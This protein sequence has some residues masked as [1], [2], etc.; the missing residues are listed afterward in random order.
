MPLKL[1]LNRAASRLKGSS[2]SLDPALPLSAMFGLAM[3]R[4][5]WLARGTLAFPLRG[6]KL[7]L[8][9]NVILRNRGHF[10]FGN[11][12]TLAHGC[13]IDGLSKNG[14]KLGRNV[15]VGPNTIIQA[16]GVLSNLGTG[17]SIG[18]NSGI[19]GFSF[20]GCGGGVTIG[21]NVIMGQ[22]VSFHSENH[23]I[24]RTDVPI[25]VQGVTRKGIVVE[26]DCWVGAKTTFLDG[27]HI[28]RGCVIA[29]GSVVRGDI[30][31]YS[32]AAGVPAKV[33]R[34]RLP[35]GQQP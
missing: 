9:P 12:T 32:I 28:G 16:S 7:F 8:G 19:G 3:R 20:V 27:S 2:Y 23:V 17:C 31:A 21:S 24:D 10:A 15:N 5:A 33:I 11:G 35:Q 30:P 22:Y 34:S 4:A 29:A 18:D 26:D 13:L 6:K 1:L 14:V 25:R